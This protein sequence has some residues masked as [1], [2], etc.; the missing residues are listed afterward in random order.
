MRITRSQLLLLA[1][2]GINFVVLYYVARTQQGLDQGMGPGVPEDGEH[3]CSRQTSSNVIY[4]K[5]LVTFVFREFENFNNMIP[6]TVSS[7]LKVFPLAQILIISDKQPYPPLS[8][9]VASSNN[10]RI[11][12]M[13]ISPNQSQY[14]SRPENF[15]KTEYVIFLPDGIEILTSSAVKLMV[16]KLKSIQGSKQM[17]HV[18]LVAL[19]V[20]AVAES[21]LAA[22]QTL[23]VDL[24]QWTL[25]YSSS[26]SHICDTVSG[27]HAVLLRTVD[28]VTLGYP[29]ARPMQTSL[30]IQTTLRQWK[31]ALISSS[32]S[33]S[34]E[35]AHTD[36][37]SQWKYSNNQ[38]ERVTNLYDS[39]GIKK[40]VQPTGEIEWYGCKRDT[41]RCFGTIIDDMPEYLYEGRW[42]PPCCMEHLR[43]TAHYVFRILDSASI[44]YWLEGGS[45]LGAAR[46]GDIIPWDYDVDVGMY[47]DD[48][49]KCPKLA[50]LK[51]GIPSVDDNGYVWEKATE[52]DFYR[53]QYSVSNHMH[54]DIFPFYTKDGIMTK[55]SWF[56]THR[57]DTEFPE[58]YLKPLT[59][60]NFAGMQVSAPNN[61]REFLE[62]KFGEGVIENPQ[63]PDPEKLK[64]PQN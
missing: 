7:V 23:N 6:K 28:L 8:L 11:V 59:K 2:I 42:T 37:H 9:D 54:V 53:V 36:A 63:Y 3:R 64:M 56:K 15:I 19:K 61:V 32:E 40:V 26:G 4:E 17:H 18:R 21:E 1:A 47:K 35:T 51:D 20:D 48:I 60:I 50:D 22:C 39:F 55:D 38:H 30:Y 25:M 52:G 27:T 45:L 13:G 44:R 34:M 12:T 57:Q 62:F 5:D 33:V 31:V 43:E 24:K 58:H 49:A 46:H 16:S 14:M 10:I 29:Y 41:A